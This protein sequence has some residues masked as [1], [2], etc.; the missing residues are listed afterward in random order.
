MILKG[1]EKTKQF[2]GGWT[3]E[4]ENRLE[5]K[6]FQ[7][8]MGSSD[9]IEHE[10]SQHVIIDPVTVGAFF[11]VQDEYDESGL[12]KIFCFMLSDHAVK[13]HLIILPP[14]PQKKRGVFWGG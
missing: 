5:I 12:C 3:V 13:R 14:F 4:T 8:Y 11:V 7:A 1:L 2:E 10:R 6:R 9:N